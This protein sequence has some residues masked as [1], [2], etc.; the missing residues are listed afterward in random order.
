MNK[1]HEF[2]SR[3]ELWYCF[4]IIGLESK[5]ARFFIVPSAVVAKYVRAQHSLWLKTTPTARD[6]P[7]RQFHIGFKAEK[8]RIPTA[9]VEE[10]EDRLELQ[11]LTRANEPYSLELHEKID[12]SRPFRVAFLRAPP[13]QTADPPLS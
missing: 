6:S 1:K 9:T 10:Y 5:L 3:P 12:D 8:Y 13:D 11:L 7:M 4:I 2:I